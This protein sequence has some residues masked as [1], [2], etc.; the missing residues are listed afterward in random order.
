M[1]TLTIYSFDELS[2][3]N[4]LT[5]GYFFHFLDEENVIKDL[6][7]KSNLDYESLIKI[8]EYIQNNTSEKFK[9]VITKSVISSKD[10]VKRYKKYLEK[11]E[12]EYR[13]RSF[14]QINI[15][16]LDSLKDTID[17]LYKLSQQVDSNL[18]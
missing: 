5:D 13:S 14:T 8:T 2:A 3:I 6:R 16:E 10:D 1:K 12:I 9:K 11:A 4:K 17:K 18:R 15:Y 7:Y